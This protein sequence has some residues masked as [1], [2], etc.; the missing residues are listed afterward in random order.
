MP[1]W[2]IVLKHKNGLDRVEIIGVGRDPHRPVD[3]TKTSRGPIGKRVLERIVER[4]RTIGTPPIIPVF[5]EHD[6][7]A[8]AYHAGDVV[9]NDSD[10]ELESNLPPLQN[11]E[12]EY[13]G[14]NGELLII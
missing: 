11:P 8:Y 14:E 9:D 3:V 10:W 13:E 2:R 12:D 4:V 7:Y 1:E 5:S 6:F